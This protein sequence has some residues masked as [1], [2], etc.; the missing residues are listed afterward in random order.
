MVF[1]G[2]HSGFLICRF[3]SLDQFG[4]FLAIIS[5]LS[6]F[7]PCPLSSLPLDSGRYPCVSPLT[8]QRVCGDVGPLSYWLANGDEST[9]SL[10]FHPAEVCGHLITSLHSGSLGSLLSLYGTHRNEATVFLV[11][12]ARGDRLKSESFLSC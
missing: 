5:F 4:K 2:F 7:Q 9:G 1:F 12:L 10:F 6:I 3:M 11:C 8:S